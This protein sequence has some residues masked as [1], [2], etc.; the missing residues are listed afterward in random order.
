[1][2]LLSTSSFLVSDK[3]LHGS[4]QMG[5]IRTVNAALLQ[6]LSHAVGH[7]PCLAMQGADRLSGCVDDADIA[8]KGLHM[9]KSCI[10]R[11]EQPL[12]SVVDHWQGK[13]ERTSSAVT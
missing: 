2:A 13:R 3:L 7:V 8:L 9:L 10:H 5:E 4:P 6:A 1:M 12:S 11:P